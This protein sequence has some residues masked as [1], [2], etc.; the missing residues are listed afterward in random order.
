MFY[1]GIDITYIILVLPAVIFAFIMQSRV[2]SV[3]NKYSRISNAHGYTGAEIAY[4]V[5]R[6]DGINDVTVERTTGTLSDHYDP[7]KNVIR[8]SDAVYNGNSVAAAGIAAHECGHAAQYDSSYG[9][10]KIRNAIIPVSRFGSM[11]AMPLI[12]L[13]FIFSYQSLVTAGII[14]FAAAIAFQ[15]ITLPVEF[16][17]SKRA[18]AVLTS[19]NILSPNETGMAKQVLSA[20]A[21]TYVAA[22]AV[23]IAQ[24]LR[25]LILFGGSRRRD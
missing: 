17:A 6:A 21:M 7:R 24:L 23:S 13:G 19:T 16:N 2:T 5:L 25:L 9:P 22:L 20:A 12:L 3:Y 10:I 18:L 15:L 14:F 4:K 1:Y 8:L 11:M